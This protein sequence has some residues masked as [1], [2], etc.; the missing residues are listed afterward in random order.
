MWR[1]AHR[2]VVWRGYRAQVS[3]VS[4]SAPLAD[5]SIAPAAPRRAILPSILCIILALPLA[6]Y[7]SVGAYARYTADDYCWAGVLR[8]EGFWQA[9]MLWYTGYSPR[10]AFTFLVNAAELA[11]PAIVPF[12]PT[13]AILVWV[14]V[15]AWMFRQ[16]DVRLGLISDQVAALLL[17]EL[18]AL[19]A[20]ATAPDLAQ[21]LYWQTGMLTYLLPL[22]L[23]TAFVGWVARAVR[24]GLSGPIQWLISLAITYVAGGLSETYLIPQNV[25]LTLAVLVA[26]VFRRDRS[27][28]CAL[29][30]LVAGLSGGCWRSDDRGRAL[31]RPAS[32]ARPTCGWPRRPRSLP[33]SPGVAQCAVPHVILLCLAL[34]GWSK[35]ARTAARA[36]TRH[37][38]ASSWS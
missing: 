5:R 26:L 30:L 2:E 23:M 6:T 17:A 36:A 8:T 15:L 9:Q 34:P 35:L 32:A 4:K 37:R 11:G 27:A 31:D 13:L 38:R 10:Y 28:R 25:A 18:I 14:G 33:R 20:L 19:A 21:S 1:A 12:L 29:P 22:V 7:A 24:L 16:L 3:I